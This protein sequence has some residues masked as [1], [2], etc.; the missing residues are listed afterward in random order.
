MDRNVS[1]DE[2]KRAYKKA[3]IKNHPDKG[4]DPE[5]A[6]ARSTCRRARER[7][8]AR[9]TRAGL[10]L[11]CVGSSR[12]FRQRMRCWRT[13]RSARFTTNTARMR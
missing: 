13:P 6:R 4:G 8:A 3:A 12:R 9:L 1:P 10:G 5:K 2:L 11:A 7:R